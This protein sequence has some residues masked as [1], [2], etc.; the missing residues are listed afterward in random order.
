MFSRPAARRPGRRGHGAPIGQREPRQGSWRATRRL[1]GRQWN[2]ATH[3]QGAVRRAGGCRRP[4]TGPFVPGDRTL[5]RPFRADLGMTFPQWRTRLR[6]HRALILLA[7]GVPVTA[8][9][10]RCRWGD[11]S[12]A[13]RPNSGPSRWGRTTL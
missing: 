8:V 6:L 3:H 2:L 1:R 10:H 5:A 13:S 7:D 12:R 11:R 9:A 4:H